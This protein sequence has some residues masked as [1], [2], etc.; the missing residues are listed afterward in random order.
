MPSTK[1]YQTPWYTLQV[2][3]KYVIGIDEAGRGPL[4]GPVS[5]G[6]VLLPFRFNKRAFKG[7]KDSKQLT[8]DQREKWYTFLQKEE[9][10]GSLKYAVSFSDAS[11]IDRRGIVPAIR[12]ALA[13]CLHKLNAD[14]SECLILLDGSLKAPPEFTFQKTIIRGD[15]T[16]VPISLASVAAKV[17]R[18]RRMVRLAKRYP[19]YKFDLHKGY[20]TLTH[21]TLIRKLGLCDLHRRTFI[22]LEAESGR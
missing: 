7:I 20:G 16:E 22:H 9:Q 8:L 15:E 1:V 21:R 10:K 14:P 6:A 13:R 4:A 2:A 18:D 5:V 17:E 3:L 19:A 11:V 12:Q